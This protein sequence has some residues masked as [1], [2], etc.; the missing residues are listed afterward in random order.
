MEQL[1]TPDKWNNSLG[2]VK[3]NFYVHHFSHLFQRFLPPYSVFISGCCN[4]GSPPTFH[5]PPHSPV[6]PPCL[7]TSH[8]LSIHLYFPSQNFQPPLFHDYHVNPI[9]D[10]FLLGLHD[11]ALIEVSHHPLLRFHI[12]MFFVHQ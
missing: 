5:T 10:I 2:T 12:C 7:P 11:M 4:D 9:L 3:T 8:F 1:C 6:P